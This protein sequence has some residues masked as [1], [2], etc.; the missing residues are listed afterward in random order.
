M[1]KR[2]REWELSTKEVG[3]VDES[4]PKEELSTKR[5]DFVEKKEWKGGCRE[6]DLRRSENNSTPTS[7]NKH[8]SQKALY[9]PA[10]LSLIHQQPHL[11]GHSSIH[12]HAIK[13]IVRNS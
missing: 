11:Y 13:Y 2:L 12:K 8:S 9:A 7:H 10:Q 5:A 6:D 3:F 1:E 4:H